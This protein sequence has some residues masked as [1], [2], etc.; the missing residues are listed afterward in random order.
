MCQPWTVCLSVS[1]YVSA[2]NVCLSVSHYV[3]VMNVCLS[4][5]HYVSTMNRVCLSVT[6]CQ[7]WTVCLSVSHYVSTMNHVSVYQSLCVNH[8]PCVCLSV[9][10]C[11]PWT[12]VC[13]SPGV[14]QSGVALGDVILPPWAKGDPREFV[15]AHREVS[16]TVSP[17]NLTS[18]PVHVCDFINTYTVVLK[19]NLANIL[20][21]VSILPFTIIP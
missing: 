19:H 2:M 3:S 11:Q 21:Q 10:M 5:S 18:D 17:S 4:V 20:L 1:H 8:E 15:R 16:L 13:L 6:V 12:C 7:P 14:K 9:T